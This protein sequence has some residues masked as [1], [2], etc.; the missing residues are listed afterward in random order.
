MLFGS[1]ISC[2]IG[3]NELER[4]Y[5]GTNDQ[6]QGRADETYYIG[7]REL[8]E[9][10][11]VNIPSNREAQK[12]SMAHM[13]LGAMSYVSRELGDRFTRSQIEN[14]RVCDVLDLLDGKDVEIRSVDPDEVR[15]LLAQIESQKQQISR[16]QKFISLK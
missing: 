16:Y 14:L 8:I 9:Y 4:G 13:S 1:L 10:S 7:K 6:A 3:F 2:S 12:R 5:W 15:R 11:I